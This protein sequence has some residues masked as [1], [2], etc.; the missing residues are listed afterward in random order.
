MDNNSF[1]NFDP[2]QNSNGNP[3]SNGFSHT[4][5][6]DT[7]FGAVNNPPHEPAPSN[8]APVVP[9][10]KAGYDFSALNLQEP[11]IPEKPSISLTQEK[12]DAIQRE[13]A[14][15]IAEE[16]K[17][18]DDAEQVLHMPGFWKA[19]EIFIKATQRKRS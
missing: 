19:A 8:Q 2:N 7:Q 3:P 11:A 18:L 4:T 15:I 1:N 16:R 5:I 10:P 13:A 9:T 6:N 12:A 17:A 14:S